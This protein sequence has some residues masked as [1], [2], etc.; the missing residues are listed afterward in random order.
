MKQYIHIC[1]CC[2]ILKLILH[3][4]H[5][6]YGRNPFLVIQVEERVDNDGDGDEE[7]G[8]RVAEAVEA[9]RS[10]GQSSLNGE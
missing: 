5:R 9:H 10:R 4:H 7:V 2:G 8:R 6:Q 1:P 3:F